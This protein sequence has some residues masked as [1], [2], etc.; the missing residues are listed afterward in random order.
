MF[1]SQNFKGAVAPLELL[2][3]GE[4]AECFYEV[5]PGKAQAAAKYFTSLCVRTLKKVETEKLVAVNRSDRLV[6]LLRVKV[7]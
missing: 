5:E 4:G 6:T 7:L 2:L 3:M 1:H